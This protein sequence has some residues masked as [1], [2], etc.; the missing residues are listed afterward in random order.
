MKNI[1]AG[2]LRLIRC[3]TT[4]N[5]KAGLGLQRWSARHQPV[6]QAQILVVQGLLCG[7]SSEKV[8]YY[9]EKGPGVQGERVAKIRILKVR[10]GSLPSNKHRE[11]ANSA[12]PP[13]QISRGNKRAVS[14][15]G[16]FGECARVPV[17][18]TGEHP[19]VPSFRLLVPGSIRMNPRPV[20][21]SGIIR[22]NHPLGNHPFAN[23]RKLLHPYS[24]SLDLITM[25]HYITVKLQV[26]GK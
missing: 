11:W 4:L 2:P 23:L 25:R 16:G 15:K 24:H 13:F 1:A 5:P 14:Q 18:G 8:P 10:G 3:T 19:N 26:L 7:N 17:F 21:W 20:F 12:V 6:V 9:R 22:Q